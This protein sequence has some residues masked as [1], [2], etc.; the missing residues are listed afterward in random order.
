MKLKYEIIRGKNV[1]HHFFRGKRYPF[2]VKP[3]Y[4]PTIRK[5]LRLEKEE[6][7]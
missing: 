5:D 6:S 3:L 4:E 2:E 7:K 1:T